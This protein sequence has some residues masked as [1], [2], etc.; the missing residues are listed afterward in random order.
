M[1]HVLDKSRNYGTVIAYGDANIHHVFE[2]DGRCFDGNGLEIDC[3]T[4][5][6]IGEAPPVTAAVPDKKPEKASSYTGLSW[7]QEPETVKR[8]VTLDYEGELIPV[9]LEESEY[10]TVG[11]IKKMLDKLGGEYHPNHKRITLW[12]RLMERVEELS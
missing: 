2:Q 9:D 5:A 4:G 7:D 6:L 10:E 3:K 1:S 12:K 11:D 8:L